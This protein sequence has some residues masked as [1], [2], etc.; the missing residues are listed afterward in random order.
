MRLTH[1]ALGAMLLAATATQPLYAKTVTVDVTSIV[2]HPALDSVKDGVKDQ[3]AKAG[4]TEGH[5]LNWEFQTAQGNQAIAA[6][7]AR[8]YVGAN[9]DMIVAI[10]TPSAQAAVAATQTRHLDDMGS[11]ERRS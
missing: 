10:A 2:E 5:G 9:P 6:K 7:I 11:E 1:F 4:Y 3:L 8:N